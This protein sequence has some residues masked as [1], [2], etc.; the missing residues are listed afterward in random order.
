MPCY[1]LG[2]RVPQIDPTAFVHPDAVVVGDV[3]IGPESTIW[4]AAVLRGAFMNHTIHHRAQLGVYLRLN[5]VPVPALYGPSADEQ[6]SD[7]KDS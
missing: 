4:P 5:E 6:F 1:A 7:S 3:R 2:D